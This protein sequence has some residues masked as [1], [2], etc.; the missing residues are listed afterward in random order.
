MEMSVHPTIWQA[1]AE[2]VAFNAAGYTRTIIDGA[3]VS[4]PV[5]L[6][7]YD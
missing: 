5:K 4:A 7:S 2:V 1:L 3:V 6:I